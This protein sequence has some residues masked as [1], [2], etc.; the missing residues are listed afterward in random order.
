MDQL[1]IWL[2][3]EN[4]DVLVVGGGGMAVAK[5]RIAAI[6][7]ANVTFVAPSI[8]SEA[9][10]LIAAGTALHVAREFLP[11]DIEGQ[12]LVFAATGI[13]PV[14]AAVAA[15][16]NR[17]NVPVNAPDRPNLS[18]FIMPAIVDRGPVVVGIST[19]GSAPALAR[20]IRGQIDS[21]LPAR[22][23]DLAHLANDFR[24]AVKAKI[25]RGLARLRFWDA[26][27]GGPVAE[28]VLAGDERAAQR[29]FLRSLNAEDAQSDPVG[30]VH[31][32]G[33]GPGDP[34][35]LT[36]R[37]LRLIQAAD[38]VVFDRLVSA[39]ILDYARRDATRIDVG[40]APGNHTM[41]Q[42]QI[43]RVLVTQAKAGKRVV[44]L[45]GGDPFVFGRGGE[46][47]D[48]LH[49][50]GIETNVVPGITAAL[51]CAAA[52]GIP[53]THRKSASAVTFLTGH[54]STDGDADHDWG[55]LA[56]SGHTLAVYMGVGAAG[57]IA[58]RL[59]KHGMHPATP[60]AII[61]NGTRTN[62][63]VVGGRLDE[64]ATVIS[65][66]GIGNP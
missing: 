13:E 40:K 54:T 65:A 20:K 31:V 15:A 12:A 42:D 9:K 1:P 23:G 8:G 64:L 2:T 18:E 19:G 30:S 59:I 32:V 28:A 33:A 39:E 3:I 62:Q 60:V 37:A 48:Y 61:E 63:R 35:L 38:V 27:F 25:P 24:A 52:A 26:L 7:G 55:S 34:D 44:R 29:H 10:G 47:V 56:K 41:D 16:A 5:A 11:Q 4:R 21:I 51:A 57:S 43:N 53:L 36:L 6:A 45:K 66:H 17:A 58:E 49:N 22:L 46:E 50:N 14:D